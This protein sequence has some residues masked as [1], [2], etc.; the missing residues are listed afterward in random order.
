MNRLAIDYDDSDRYIDAEYDLPVALGGCGNDLA[1]AGEELVPL[2]LLE[3][4]QLEGRPGRLVDKY[5]H[6]HSEAV[7]RN[8][9]PAAIRALGIRRRAQQA[10][11]PPS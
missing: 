10:E 4:Q 6:P 5:G 9:S 11:T 3:E 8:W 2:V 1:R 7:L